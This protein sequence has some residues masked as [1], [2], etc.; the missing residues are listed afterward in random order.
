MNLRE[1]EKH[2][3]LCRISSSEKS[4]ASSN[5][6]VSNDYRLS[7]HCSEPPNMYSSQTRLSEMDENELVRQSSDSAIPTSNRPNIEV[8]FTPRIPSIESQ[9]SNSLKNSL[10]KKK[11]SAKSPKAT[12]ANSTSPIKSILR[13]VFTAHTSTP[14]NF[15]RRSLATSEYVLTPIT[16]TDNSMSPITQSATKMSKAMQVCMLCMSFSLHYENDLTSDLGLLKL[17]PLI[18]F[19]H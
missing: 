1:I 12:A 13:N 7:R 18:D 14:S 6:S 10:K 4:H 3:D 16:D 19:V 2:K 9:R 5:T 8:V 17:R 15:L 11:N